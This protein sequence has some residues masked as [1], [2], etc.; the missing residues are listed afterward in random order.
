MHFA[1]AIARVALQVRRE[2]VSQQTPGGLPTGEFRMRIGT[3]GVAHGLVGSC[4]LL[5]E[6]INVPFGALRSLSVHASF[7]RYTLNSDFTMCL[8]SS[9]VANEGRFVKEIDSL[10]RLETHSLLCIPI[11]APHHHSISSVHLSASASAS[12][13]AT[14]PSASTSLA[15]APAAHPRATPLPAAPSFAAV[16][17][18]PSLIAMQ[19]YAPDQT[20]TSSAPAVES[21][22]ANYLTADLYHALPDAQARGQMSQSLHYQ[23]RNSATHDSCF[24]SYNRLFRVENQQCFAYISKI[25]FDIC[26]HSYVPCL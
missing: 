25:C 6:P 4:A 23:S 13:N 1:L 17:T 14:A 3:A 20:T 15:P 16:A 12:A 8:V 26:L 11:R 10:P 22:Y 24:N 9:A 5:G 18:V 19:P 2:I 7:S 21:I